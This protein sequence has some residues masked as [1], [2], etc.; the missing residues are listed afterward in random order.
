MSYYQ[1]RGT[2]CENKTDM[3]I[4]NYQ[5]FPQMCVDTKEH[6]RVAIIRK[7]HTK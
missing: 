2:V 3:K 1:T 4:H 6:A 5:E 7:H